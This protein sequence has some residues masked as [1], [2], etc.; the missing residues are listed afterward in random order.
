MLSFQVLEQE[1][2]VHANPHHEEDAGV[3][4]DMEDVAVSDAEEGLPRKPRQNSRLNMV[5]RSY[6]WSRLTSSVQ[7]HVVKTEEEAAK[8]GAFFLFR[9]TVTEARPPR[10]HAG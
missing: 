3:Q 1:A 9:K 8:R 7:T 2:P 10:S 4:I 5:G 6:H